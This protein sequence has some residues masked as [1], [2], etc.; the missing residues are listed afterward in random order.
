MSKMCQRL[1]KFMKKPSTLTAE[2]LQRL[3]D[4]AT[5]KKGES[6]TNYNPKLPP[7]KASPFVN[8]AAKTGGPVQQPNA[9]KP[10]TSEKKMAI[11]P[12]QPKLH[13]KEAEGEPLVL[14]VKEAAALLKYSEKKIYDYIDNDILKPL[15]GSRS[16][17]IPFS[18]VKAL[19]GG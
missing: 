3:N 6:K 10:V 4:S 5:S 19:C 14:T 13:K 7:S 11:A 17:R 9:A 2:E 18:Q 1:P 12:S 16:Y 15:P 8:D